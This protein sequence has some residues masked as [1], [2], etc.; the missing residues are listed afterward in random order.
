MAIPILMYH[1]IDVDCSAKYARWMVTPDRL[2]AQLVSFLDRG[3]RFL[4]VSELA[5]ARERG[6]N[7]KLAAITFDDGLADFA[8]GAMPVLERLGVPATLFV[9]TGYVGATARWLTDLDEG[10]RPMLSRDDL[11]AL[12][13]SG[14][15]C[16]AHSHTHPQLD[17]LD[18]VRANRE[19]C[20][21][22]D[23][24]GD[25]MGEA[26]KSF[27]YPHGYSTRTVRAM[28]SRAGF[29]A[30]CRVAHALSDE[31]EDRYALSRIIMTQDID[32]LTLD[33]ILAGSDIPLTPPNDS[34]PIR[35]WRMV[36][37]IKSMSA[38]INQ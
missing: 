22:R 7:D 29:D 33:T 3:Y 37:Q 31:F 2:E 20:T 10:A 6:A 16:G 36:R 12:S 30:A 35:A 11:R 13:R 32:A 14:V 15:E 1:S 26:P 8:S 18:D 4:T 24:L 38:R 23:R 17:L 5:S 34:I 27:A 28:V 21:S 9:A 19:I 25:W